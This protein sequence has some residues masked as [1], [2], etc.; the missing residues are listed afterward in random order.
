MGVTGVLS[1]TLDK[2]R[3]V[4]PVGTVS[5]GAPGVCAPHAGLCELFPV[6]SA[7]S[8][9]SRTAL[10]HLAYCLIL[11]HMLKFRAKSKN[12]GFILFFYAIS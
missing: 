11:I 12:I 6:F 10:Y 2:P 5:G 7:H 9:T 1:G 8:G 3:V 4:F